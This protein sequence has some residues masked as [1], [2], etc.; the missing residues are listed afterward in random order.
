[1]WQVKVL[2]LF[3]ELYP[4]PLNVSVVGKA[5]EDNLWSL[6][7]YNIR[8][9]AKDKHQTVDDS[10]YGGGTGMVMKPDVLADAIENVFIPNGNP[11]YYLSPRGK[12]FTQKVASELSTLNGINLLCGRFEGIDERIFLEY[13]VSELSLG[14][15]V[16]SSGDVAAYPILDSCV[17]LIP[18]VLDEKSALLEESFG[19]SPMYENLLE[20]PHYTKPAVW[21][22]HQVPEILRSGNHKAIDN[23]RLE[24]AISK[25]KSVRP[26]LLDRCLN[27]EK[28]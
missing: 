23:W 10:P 11:I 1:M 12:V 13:S 17:R 25:T 7:A 9:Y 27:G 28:K 26:E 18:G 20:Y 24:Q 4:G 19:L 14:D 6:E 2:T 8:D 22:G 5:L 16:L 3:P 15:F 21:R